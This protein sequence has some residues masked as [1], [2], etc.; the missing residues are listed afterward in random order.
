MTIFVWLAVG[1]LQ[2]TRT[3]EFPEDSQSWG[4]RIH[5]TVE[6]ALQFGKDPDADGNEGS[7]SWRPAR[8]RLR[9]TAAP[10]SWRPARARLRITAAPASWR[11]A[12]ARLRITA[13]P[14]SWRPARARLRIT[15]APASWRPARARLR[16]TAA[17]ASWRPA[18]ARLR[19]TAAPASWRPARARLRITAAPA[20]RHLLCLRIPKDSS[21]AFGY[22]SL[23]IQHNWIGL[24]IAADILKSPE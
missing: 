18:R 6:G 3:A 13:A 2:P 16:I 9:I 10:A 8:A 5:P 22:L 14:A 12:R 23:W 17:P 19:I 4:G 20:L 11:P 21:L 7:A 1:S 24:V 15:A